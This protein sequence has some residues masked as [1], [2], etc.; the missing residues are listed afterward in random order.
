MDQLLVIFRNPNLNKFLFRPS[1]YC[2]SNRVRGA[3]V[4]KAPSKRETVEQC[5]RTTGERVATTKSG[6]SLADKKAKM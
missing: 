1:K 6:S 4:S 5:S 3:P 2:T